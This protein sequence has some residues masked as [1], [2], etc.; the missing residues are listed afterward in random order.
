MRWTGVQLLRLVLACSRPQQ[1][2]DLWMG[3][4][5]FRRSLIGTLQAQ[6]HLSNENGLLRFQPLLDLEDLLNEISDGML[7][8]HRNT[9]GLG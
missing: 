8:R 5:S 3:Q 7:Q 6:P 2:N 4:R 1:N 9:D